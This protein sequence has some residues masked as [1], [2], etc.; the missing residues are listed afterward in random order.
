MQHKDLPETAYQGD[1][2]ADYDKYRFETPGGCKV[3]QIEVNKLLSAI[4]GLPENTVVL[5]AGCGTGRFLKRLADLGYSPWGLD[6]SN[7]M[8]EIC[9]GKLGEGSRERLVQGEGERLPFEDDRFDFTYSIRVLNQV[10]S[11][12]YAMGFIRELIR[13]TSGG[14]RVLV[15]YMDIRRQK[16]AL[17]RFRHG[18]GWAS[19]EQRG[20]TRLDADEIKKMV[21]GQG[22]KV[23]WIQGAFFFGMT[24]YYVLP[25]LL[26]PVLVA[27]DSL[28]A[29]M[30][31]RLC[32]R[33]YFLIQK[34]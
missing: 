23:V 18:S 27:T 22:C 14:A 5:E 11:P 33:V 26:L 7:D 30:F 3:N 32:S 17:N 10:E 1:M 6:P 2:A 12:E 29:K 19:D 31:P 24:P 8:L 15:E 4:D 21:E 28:A 20:D 16:I 13:V 25:K 9:A 34:P